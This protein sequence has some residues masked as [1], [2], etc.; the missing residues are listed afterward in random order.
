M[1]SNRTSNTLVSSQSNLLPLYCLLEDE[2]TIPT[3]SINARYS[4]YKEFRTFPQKV[5]A[6]LRHFQPQSGCF[7]KCN[8]CSQGASSR[9][10]EFSLNNLRNIIAAIKAVS[11]EQTYSPNQ[12]TDV[13]DFD[14]GHF[15]DPK[16]IHNSPLIAYGREDRRGVI[17]CYLDNDP[18]IYPHIDT[19]SQLIYE[20]LGVK[21]RIATVGYSRHN[22]KIRQAFINLSNP[23][24]HC[25]AGV[26]LSISPYTYGWTEAGMRAGATHRDEF[27][28]D[29]AHFINTFKGTGSLFSAELRFRPMVDVGEIKLITYSGKHILAYKNYLYVS[30]ASLESLTAASISD[31]HDHAL[32]MDTQGHKVI[33]L[34]VYGNWKKSVDLYLHGKLDGMPCLMHKLQND[35]GIYFGVNVERDQSGKCYAKFFYPKSIAR[36]QSGHIDGERYLLNAMI[37]TKITINNVFWQDIDALIQGLKDKAQTLAGIFQA[38]S[39]YI[40]ND[41]IPLIE[42]YVRILKMAK[43]SANSFL[44]K[45]LT[46]DTGQICNLGRAFNEYKLL[47]SRQ[48]LPMT[49]NHE[50]AFGKKGDL[51][52]EGTVFRLSPG[53]RQRISNKLGRTNNKEN[54]F[55]IEEL[56]L[57]LTS[58]EDGQSKQYYKFFLPGNMVKSMKQYDEPIIVGQI[59]TRVTYE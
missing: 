40:Q 46:I 33:Q 17:Y 32:K 41:I 27:E 38:S 2:T 47:A 50:R 3:D 55:I 35:D 5:F 18:A 56:D 6:R 26:R 42:S 30:D 43:L 16:A 14:T 36:P 8:F 22:Q 28:E 1:N 57:S 31:S 24:R 4:L 58:S 23:L 39:N 19:F 7:N 54:E 53:G 48:D 49:P 45:A 34:E 44:D 13:I 12:I 59:P 9:I 29:L 51:A 15:I 37:D 52:N 11:L 25:L 10:I 21:T 20:N